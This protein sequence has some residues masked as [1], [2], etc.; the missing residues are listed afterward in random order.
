MENL[1]KQIR[2]SF[3]NPVL[4]LLPLLMFLVIDEF[5]GRE[6]AWEISFPVAM[7]LGIYV[8]FAY[9]E[10]FKWH[11]IF[12]SLFVGVIIMASLES[13][14]SIPPLLHH[15]FIEIIVLVIMTVF[16]IFRT[17][18]QNNISKITSK[19]IP[20]SNNFV[21][22]YRAI[23]ALS[24]VLALY[25]SIYLAG[26]FSE[27]Y[28]SEFPLALLQYLYAGILVFLILYE[29]VRVQFVRATLNK[30]EWWP[31][32]SDQGKII[33]SIHHL[34][35]LNDS[36]KY[37]HPIIR[38]MLIDRGLVLLQK[39]SLNNTTLPGIWDTAISN[40]V[41]MNETID[42]CVDRTAIE[43]YGLHNFKYMYLSN[44]S[45]EATNEHHYAFLFVSCQLVQIQPNLEFIDQAKW[46]TQNQIE[47]NLD[48]GIFSENF[49]IEYDLLKRSGVLESGRCEC[50]CRL[51]EEIYHQ[52]RTIKK[53]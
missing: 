45:L 24:I 11:M 35:S 47:D 6:L 14:F 33:G 21:E 19:L 42:Q 25:I 26:Y 20:M 4:H 39:I 44:Y 49:K 43:R 15:P 34:T 7:I 10:L 27:R 50:A 52:S 8:F 16:L 22:M 12:T 9:N 23:W 17:I 38:V 46:W 31:I 2:E 53:E 1:S 37:K 40:H 32:V 36:N 29:I 41:K 3:F 18:I 30:E 48:T 28:S 51:K 5:Y 13:Y